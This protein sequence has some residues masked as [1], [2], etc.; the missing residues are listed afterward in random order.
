[1]IHESY[2]LYNCQRC[3]VQV[4]ICRRCDRGNVYCGK[5]CAAAARKMNARRYSADYQ[6]TPEGR[7]N[8]KVREQRY[9]ERKMTQHCSP[10]ASP[11]PDSAPIGIVDAGKETNDE[12]FADEP[13]DPQVVL[14]SFCR[15]PCGTFARL[16]PL[17]RRGHATRR[18]PRLPCWSG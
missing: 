16:Q 15:R 4:K 5:D 2:R 8:H 7:D 11:V 6:S 1:V 3:H 12:S 9:V 14:C 18:G 10:R 13:T 17:R